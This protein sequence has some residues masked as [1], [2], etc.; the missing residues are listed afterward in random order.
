MSRIDVV[1]VALTHEIRD[2]CLCLHTQRA[3]RAMARRYDE[4]FRSVELTNGQFSLLV[5][6]NRETPAT[7][8]QVSAVLGMDRTTI[9]ANLKP[10]ERRGLVTVNV[11]PADRRSRLV[12]LTAKGRRVLAKA[13]PLWKQTQSEVERLVRSDA[14]RAELLAILDRDT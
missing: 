5:A 8:G 9:T 12:T 4:A 11:N 13:I 2:C 7:L 14:L 10:L 1:P 3:A 6:V